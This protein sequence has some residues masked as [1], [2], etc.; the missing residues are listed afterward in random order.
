MKHILIKATFMVSL[1]VLTAGVAHAEPIELVPNSDAA[2]LAVESPATPDIE[3]RI[4]GFEA[5]ETGVEAGTV[6]LDEVHEELDP[7]AHAAAEHANAHQESAGLPQL[8]PTWFASQAFWLLL[9]F[10]FLY[11]YFSRTI[12]PAISN[13]LENRH[14]HVQ[15][16]LDMA[17]KLKTEAEQVFDAYNKSLDNARSKAT[18]LYSDVEDDIKVKSERQQN[19]LRD[20]LAKEME[21]SEARLQKTKNDALKEMDN[22]AAEIASAAAQKIVGISTDI[23]TAREIVQGLNVKDSKKAA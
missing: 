3:E 13:T 16:D 19:E 7:A 1:A 18:K 11:M 9:I 12:L 14:E 20:R 17:Q 4:E 23:N 6:G 21:L 2:P 8:D 5:P 10:A 22:I 15:G